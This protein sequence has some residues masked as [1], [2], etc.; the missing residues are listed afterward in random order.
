MTDVPIPWR[1]D[2]GPDALEAWC[3][4]PGTPGPDALDRLLA[5]ARLH[6]AGRSL[7]WTQVWPTL[8]ADAAT[9]VEAR[10]TTAT[11]QVRNPDDPD[12]AAALLQ[13]QDAWCLHRLVAGHWTPWICLGLEALA[14]EAA[15]APLSPATAE[16]LMAW[17]TTWAA[18]P[19]VLILPT[20]LHPDGDEDQRILLACSRVASAPSPAVPAKAPTVYRFPVR[21]LAGGQYAPPTRAAASTGDLAA[22]AQVFDS[23]VEWTLPLPDQPPLRIRRHMA[24]TEGQWTLMWVITPSDRVRGVS[25]HAGTGDPRQARRVPAAQGLPEYYAIPL[26]ALDNGFL[27]TALTTLHMDSGDIILEDG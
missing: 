8:G 13:A 5:A 18:I 15:T 1:P 24:H 20:L 4:N 27:G 7:A 11:G 10:I 19:D 22:L 23:K 6:A 17:R 26:E 21:S 14:E 3:Q 25:I 2:T 9:L 12:Q 16:G